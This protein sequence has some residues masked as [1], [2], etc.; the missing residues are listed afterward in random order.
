MLHKRVDHQ[1]RYFVGQGVRGRDC[2]QDFQRGE[3]TTLVRGGTRKG[4][5]P[6]GKGSPQKVRLS[7][8]ESPRRLGR[9][10]YLDAVVGGKSS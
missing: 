1:S 9:H 6:T 10:F 5:V 7:L 3:Y 4:L 2:E 8:H